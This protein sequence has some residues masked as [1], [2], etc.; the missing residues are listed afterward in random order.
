MSKILL[1]ISYF[2]KNYCGW[3]FQINGNTVQREMS[4]AARTCYGCDIKVSGCSRTD[5]GVHALNYYCTLELPEGSPNIPLDRLPTALNVRLPLDITV[6]SAKAVSDDFHPRYSAISKTYE[7]RM[8][9][10]DYRDPFQDGRAWHVG[11]KLDE[12]IMN[13][14]AK[15]LL[16]SHDFF[17]F[18]AAGSDITDTVREIYSA[19]VTRENGLIIFRVSGNGFLYNMVRIMTGTLMDISCGRIERGS[20]PK[21]IASRD[22]TNAGRT[23]PPEGLYLLDVKYPETR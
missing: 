3:Q 17:A 20:I 8:Y 1:K 15:A 6:H 13:T 22:R 19:E 23:A 2:G 5:S 4:I 12:N 18:M 14:E 10:A 21:I 11:W 7:Y 16:G 9:D